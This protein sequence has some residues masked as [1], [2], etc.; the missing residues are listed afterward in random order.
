M[1][2]YS[3]VYIV[4]KEVSSVIIF[5]N[6]YLIYVC[7]KIG[8]SKTEIISGPNWTNCLFWPS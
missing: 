4:W 3:I 2:V 5:A 8:K 1:S 6:V 7:I